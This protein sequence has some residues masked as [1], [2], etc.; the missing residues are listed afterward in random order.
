MK[1]I[2]KIKQFLMRVHCALGVLL[3]NK[4]N[5]TLGY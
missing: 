3:G 5:F 2:L 4:Q 1:K